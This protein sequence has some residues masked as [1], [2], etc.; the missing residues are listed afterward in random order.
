L[1]KAD[2]KPI[3]VLQFHGVPDGEHPW[4]NTPRELFEQYMERLH[5]GGYRVVAMRDLA[6]W[7]DPTVE[8]GDAWEIID[9][10][11]RLFGSP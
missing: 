5:S 1:D 3:A 8:P 7:V 9:L 4:V 10:R 6:N 11:K 2:G